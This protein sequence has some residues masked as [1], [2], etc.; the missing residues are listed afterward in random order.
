TIT[1]GAANSARQIAALC[2]RGRTCLW[3]PSGYSPWG[4]FL[5]LLQRTQNNDGVDNPI[6]Y[7]GSHNE[8]HATNTITRV[9]GMSEGR[10]ISRE[11]RIDNVQN[12]PVTDSEVKDV[13]SYL[14]AEHEHPG[15][16]AILINDL[17]MKALSEE[18]VL[19]VG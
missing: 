10:R 13:L 9:V 16:H 11:Y 18:L 14:R 8:A 1:G 19:Q 15:I 7:L 12:V 4:T 6:A 5:Q 2:R 17:N 3:G